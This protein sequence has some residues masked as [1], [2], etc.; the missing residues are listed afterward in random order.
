M[1]ELF[2]AITCIFQ[3]NV[4][5]YMWRVKTEYGGAPMKNRHFLRAGRDPRSVPEY[6]PDLLGER[7]DPDV[8]HRPDRYDTDAVWDGE[9]VDEEKP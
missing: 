5:Y 8:L 1:I 6:R 7:N 3:Y 4:V 9:T 2:S